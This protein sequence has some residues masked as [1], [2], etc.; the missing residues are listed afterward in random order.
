MRLPWSITPLPS[1]LLLFLEV[2]ADRIVRLTK[3]ALDSAAPVPS[4]DP[5]TEDILAQLKI[6]EA[7]VF[8]P[9]GMQPLLNLILHCVGFGNEE[10]NS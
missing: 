1:V 5:T 7:S 3:A 9:G 2:R 6:V 10:G 4:N 8:N